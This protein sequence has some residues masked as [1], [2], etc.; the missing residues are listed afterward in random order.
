MSAVRSVYKEG[1]VKKNICIMSIFVLLFCTFYSTSYSASNTKGA[2]WLSSDG[3]GAVS[4]F[5]IPK[6]LSW[7][8]GGWRLERELQNGKKEIVAEKLGIPNN[9]SSQQSINKSHDRSIREFQEDIKNKKLS[10]EDADIAINIL[11]LKAALD[12]DFGLA[13][14]VR[15]QDSDTPKEDLVYHLIALNSKGKE[16]SVLSSR[17]VNGFKKSALPVTPTDVNGTVSDSGVY[18]SFKSL[19]QNQMMPVIAYEIEREEKNGEKHPV[20]DGP[21]L[22]V[23]K[24][25]E[26]S[27]SS[28]F[29]DFSPPRETEVKYLV[30]GV[31]LFG[32]RSQPAVFKAF[33]ED[34]SALAA[35]DNFSVIAGDNSAKLTW[36]QNKSPFTAGYIIER[37]N[38]PDGPYEAITPEGLESDQTSW[39]DKKLTGGTTYYYR[40]RSFG[41]RGDLGTP[42]LTKVAT[43]Q[44]AK[45]PPRPDNFKI[46]VGRTLIRLHWR[47]VDF[48]VAGYLVERQSEN[49][50]KWTMLTSRVV[51]MNSYD[52]HV[53]LH[54]QGKFSYRITAVGFDDKRSKPSKIVK[55]NLLDTVS[56]SPPRIT[57]ISGEN[58]KVTV[59]FKATEP[60]GDVESFLIVRSISELD[61]GLVIGDPIPAN[62]SS[63]E[64]TFVVVGERYRYQVVAVDNSGNRSDLSWVREVTVN[65]PPI[66]IPDKPELDIVE[67]PFAHIAISVNTPPEGLSTIVQRMDE[68]NTWRPVKVGYSKENVLTDMFSSKSEVVKYRLL[69]KAKNG[70][71]GEPS[72]VAEIRM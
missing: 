31:D 28:S 66:P 37:T 9:D 62:K 3:K 67:K 13:L 42:S 5:W 47:A 30:Y 50:D 23:K 68:N 70:V 64:D 38:M 63:F 59:H 58:G 35:P 16:Q 26:T 72:Q 44:N 10:K 69:Y 33:I 18:L 57:D 52:D 4:L 27:G 41:P 12:N 71:L 40:I 49:A 24:N 55:A 15:Y 2:L 36:N 14:G 54:A 19:E 29:T 1:D 34:T 21:Q 48:P 56:P 20:T 43:P 11:G 51:P 53:G 8:I 61:P 60:K 22:F 17:K 25:K 46:D 45:A 6:D 65:N 7:P 39:K 32:R